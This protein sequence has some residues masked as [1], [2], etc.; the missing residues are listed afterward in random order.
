MD[1]IK[2]ISYYGIML[3]TR[4]SDPP[5]GINSSFGSAP[6]RFWTTTTSG[7]N[8]Q[9]RA[10]ERDHQYFSTQFHLFIVLFL[11]SSTVQDD[12]RQH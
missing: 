4:G 2:K 5:T 3:R 7:P 1:D 10:L 9:R 12:I 11:N 8:K 6:L